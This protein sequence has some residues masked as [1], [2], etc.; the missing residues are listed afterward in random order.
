MNPFRGAFGFREKDIREYGIRKHKEYIK[1]KEE[2]IMIAGERF[3]RLKTAILYKAFREKF[4]VVRSSHYDDIRNGVDN[5]IVEKNWQCGLR[6]GW[7]NDK[8]RQNE[9]Y[10]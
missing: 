9:K 4:I 6:R 10:L 1:E 3:E 2:K 7:H 5:V 8:H